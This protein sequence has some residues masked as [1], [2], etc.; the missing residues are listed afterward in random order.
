[1]RVQLPLEPLA[2][3]GE[4]SHLPCDQLVDGCTLESAEIAVVDEA[5]VLPAHPAQKRSVLLDTHPRGQPVR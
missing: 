1:M 5:T 3:F 2:A 4:D